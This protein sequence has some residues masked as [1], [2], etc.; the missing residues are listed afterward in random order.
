MILTPL[1]S[2]QREAVDKALLHDG[3]A[4]IPQQRTGKTL[5]ALSIVEARRPDVLFIVCPKGAILEWQQQIERHWKPDYECL[6]EIINYEGCSHTKNQRAHYRKLIRG[7]ISEGL[8]VFS[9]CDEAHRIKKRGSFQSRFMRSI[10]KLVNWRLALTGTPMA[11]SIKDVWA[12]FEY[13]K[14]GVFGD[15]EDFEEEYIK[16]GGYYKRDIKGYKNQEKFDRIFQK[17]SYRITLNEARELMGEKPVLLKRKKIFVTLKPES[18]LH[19]E[20]LEEELETVVR[21]EKV[22]TPLILT[23]VSKLQQLAGGYLIKDIKRPGYTKKKKKVIPV[24]KEKLYALAVLLDRERTGKVVICARFIHEIDAIRELIDSEFDLTHKTIA[25]G[26]KYDNQFDTNIILL[27]IQAGV[28]I[29][30]SESNTYIFYSWDFSYINYEQAK[31]RIMSFNV[32]RVNYYYLIARDTVD[33]EIY[34][35]IAR[36]KNLA[37]L[38]C[39]HRRRKREKKSKQKAR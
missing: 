2:Y 4:L 38:I 11:Q 14:P 12:I 9:I 22:S 30:L 17:Y 23:L 21:D 3:F 19:Y 37:K 13:I 27:Q 39:D 20:E 10:G 36:K 18:R 26:K 16:Y 7:W 25:G 6:I 8:T 28:A 31:F 35:S 32:T 33:E 34:D 24:G 15:L 5:I 29:D 1:R